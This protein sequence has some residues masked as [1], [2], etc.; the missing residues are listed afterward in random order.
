MNNGIDPDLCSLLD[1]VM[2]QV[3]L[4]GQGTLLAKMDLESAYRIMPVHPSD[5]PLLG[6]Q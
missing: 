5:R 6:M 2:R 3:V 4:R 1:E